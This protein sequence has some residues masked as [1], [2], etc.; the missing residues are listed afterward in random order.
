[1]SD[2][3]SPDL[4]HLVARTL[5]ELAALRAAVERLYGLLTETSARGGLTRAT[6]T[7]AQLDEFHRT[8]CLKARIA[9]AAR[10]HGYTVEEWL[11]RHGPVDRLPVGAPRRA[12]AADLGGAAPAGAGDP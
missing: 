1:M 5:A 3:D 8:R 7:P 6:P 9:R 10:R 11:A 12:P 4:R 2:H